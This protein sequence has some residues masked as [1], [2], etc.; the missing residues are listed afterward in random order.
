MDPTRQLQTPIA[1]VRATA[2]VHV[3]SY[4]ETWIMLDGVETKVPNV[5]AARAL[6]KHQDKV[7]EQI[8]ADMDA[9]G[10]RFNPD[11]TDREEQVEITLDDGTKTTVGL[12]KPGDANYLQIETFPDAEGLFVL[13]EEKSA[14]AR[15]QAMQFARKEAKDNE[16]LINR[17]VGRIMKRYTRALKR[18]AGK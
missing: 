17:I 9:L 10:L 4:G 15:V 12:M 11:G 14:M 3:D 8:R 13:A 2:P 7:R 1:E 16:P 18:L 6:L 5:R